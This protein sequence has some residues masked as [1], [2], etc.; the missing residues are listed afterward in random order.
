MIVAAAGGVLSGRGCRSGRAATVGGV[1]V[2]VPVV[3]MVAAV[4]SVRVAVILARRRRMI[5]AAAGVTAW[6]LKA[7][8]GDRRG[9]RRRVPATAAGVAV[10]ARLMFA[11]FD[12]R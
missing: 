10:P 6:L 7:H 12:R 9:L 2:G 8:Y 4:V 5:V 1:L 11:L 3:V